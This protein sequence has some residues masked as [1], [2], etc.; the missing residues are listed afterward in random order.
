MPGAFVAP[1]SA[2]G[3]LAQQPTGQQLRGRGAI[4]RGGD[5]QA[6]AASTSWPAAG[7]ALAAAGSVASLRAGAASRRQQKRASR[8]A[9]VVR[10]AKDHINL[11]TVGHVDHGKTT[12]S[13]AISL[14]CAQFSTTQDTK[15]KTYEE[16]DNA[17]EERARGITINASHIEYETE[18]R[19][20][21]H[22][23]CPGHA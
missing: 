11:G 20:Y 22:V 15:Q 2:S 19:H 5:A 6:S 17:P 7:L 1:G 3:L 16:I 4:A 9:A 14:V 18:T 23:D 12:L 21:C 8:A 10:Q 13:A